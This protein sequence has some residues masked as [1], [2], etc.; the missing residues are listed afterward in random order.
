LLFVHIKIDI[1]DLISKLC[2]V[3]HHAYK[4]KHFL[5]VF[6]ETDYW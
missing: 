2:R 4:V 6:I 1:V 3:F 5:H